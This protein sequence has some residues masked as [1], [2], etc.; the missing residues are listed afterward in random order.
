MGATTTTAMPA[1]KMAI[2]LR[3]AVARAGGGQRDKQQERARGG[4]GNSDDIS[5]KVATADAALKP[6]WRKRQRKQ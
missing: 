6:C 4:G 1:P 5:S 2:T 3:M